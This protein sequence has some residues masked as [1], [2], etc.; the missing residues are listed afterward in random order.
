MDDRICIDVKFDFYYNNY[1]YDWFI[2]KI[3]KLRQTYSKHSKIL[4]QS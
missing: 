1:K 4:S 2:I 3:V